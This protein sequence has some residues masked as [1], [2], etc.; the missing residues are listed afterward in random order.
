MSAYR[1]RYVPGG[2]YFFTAVTHHR[3]PFLTSPLARR[4]LRAA[5][6]RERTRHPFAVEAVVLLPDHLH[7]IWTLPDGDADY[8]V[9]WAGVKTG[10]T[11]RY[12]AGGGPEGVLDHNRSRHRERA[13]W[14]HRFWEHLVRDE[15]DLSRCLDYLHYNPVKH[16]LV[17]RVADYPWSSFHRWVG[18]GEYDHEWGTGAVADVPG[19]E[20]E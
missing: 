4:S 13:V 5:I 19:A 6:D 10:F 12:L 17:A 16:G 3:R 1:R 15:A 8:S 9:R 20:W 18:L 14:Q 11:R 2:T 7:T